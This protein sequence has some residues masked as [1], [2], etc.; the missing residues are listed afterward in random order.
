MKTYN[1][2]AVSK[3]VARFDNELKTILMN[4]LKAIKAVKNEILNSINVGLNQDGLSAA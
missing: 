1:K 3:L 4:D 2:I